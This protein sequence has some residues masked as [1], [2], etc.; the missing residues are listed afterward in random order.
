MAKQYSAAQEAAL[1]EFQ[2]DIGHLN[3]LSNRNRQRL[4]MILGAAPDDEGL[5]VT[6]LAEAIHLSQPATSHHLKAL[7]EIGM[8]GSHQRGNVVYYYLTLTDTIERLERLAAA[9]RRQQRNA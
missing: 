9:L 1:K 8:V 5:M 6:E 7:K 4:L 3:A 2:T